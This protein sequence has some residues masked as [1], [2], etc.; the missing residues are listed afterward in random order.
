MKRLLGRTIAVSLLALL[1]FAAPGHAQASFDPT[2]PGQPGLALGITEPDPNFLWPAEDRTIPEPFAAW[3]TE[4]AAVRPQIYRLVPDW[5]QLPRDPT[6]PAHP[7]P[8]PGGRQPGGPP[9]PRRAG[10]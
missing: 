2:V 8:P 3:R 9:C 5:A 7:H 10:G 1:V 6:E 4:F